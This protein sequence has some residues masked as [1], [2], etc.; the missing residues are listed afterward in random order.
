MSATSDRPDPFAVHTAVVAGL[1]RQVQIAEA[2]VAERSGQPVDDPAIAAKLIAVPASKLAVLAG[3][4]R[5]I[6]RH[7]PAYAQLHLGARATA[8]L[9]EPVCRDHTRPGQVVAWPCADYRDAA[10]DLLPQEET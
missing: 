1:N 6:A 9:P 7:A 8:A 2:V 4:R 3:R 5:I 10:A